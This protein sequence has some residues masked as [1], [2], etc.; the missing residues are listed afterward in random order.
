MSTT[1]RIEYDHEKLGKM[2]Q[3]ELLIQVCGRL[4]LAHPK[5]EHTMKAKAYAL[6]IAAAIEKVVDGLP[7]VLQPL[8]DEV[9]ESLA[10]FKGVIAQ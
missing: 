8:K 7:A 2:T 10:E 4:D 5:R 1:D 9:R 3:G 6:D